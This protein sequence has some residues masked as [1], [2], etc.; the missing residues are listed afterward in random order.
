MWLTMNS[1]HTSDKWHERERA[2]MCVSGEGG[3]ISI[4][5]RA[6][7]RGKDRDTHTQT[8][9]D[10]DTHT[11][12][13]RAGECSAISPHQTRRGPAGRARTLSSSLA[14]A[15]FP[16]EAQAEMHAVHNE[17]VLTNE[18]GATH[19]DTHRHTHTDTHTLFFRALPFHLRRCG[20]TRGL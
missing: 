19:T 10:T 6:A 9:T 15:A 8:Q 7:V 18:A 12:A 5:R 4:A 13:A 20:Q 1:M 14:G 2:C 3:G 16:T 11:A 17:I